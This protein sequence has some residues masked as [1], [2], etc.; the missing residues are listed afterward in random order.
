MF[1]YEGLNDAFATKNNLSKYKLSEDSVT[2]LLTFANMNYIINNIEYHKL[3]FGDPF[4]FKITNKDGK[5]ILDETKRIKSFLSPRR[6]TFDTPEY[7]TFLNNNYNVIE[8]GIELQSGDPGYNKFD[9]YVNTV[10]L[11]D[12]VLAGS[13]SNLMKV[14]SDVKETDGFSWLSPEKYREVKLK[15]GQWSPEAE[16][17]H[18][19]QMAN[20]RNKLAAKGA[21]VYKNKD[22]EQSDIKTISKP[23]PKY[24]LEVLKPI[25]SGVKSASSTIDIVLDKFSQ[26]PIYYG[27]IENTNLEKLYLKMVNENIGYYI[28]ES[29]RKAGAGALHNLYN[30]DGS[31]NEEP[32]S[33]GVIIK[34]PWK[35]YGIQ[36][37]NSYQDNKTQTRGSQ[38]TKLSSL[39]LF[40]NGEP[41]GE[42]EERQE[43]VRKEYDRNKDLL[44]RM[45]ENAYKELL[46]RLGI[47]DLGTSF[48]L[49]D[50]KSVSETLM[51]EM[52][53][54]EVSDNTLDTIQLDDNN[55]FRI[56]LEAS[57]SYIQIRSILYSLI[58][59]A[60]VRPKMS[61]GAHVQ[62]PVTMFEQA[63]KGRSLIRKVEV[64]GVP[65]WTKI[66]K[67]E[68]AK[69]SEEEKKGVVLTDDTL[70][71]Y[72]EKDPYCEIL[73]PAWFK[74]KLS[75]G[76]YK[77]DEDILNYLNTTKEGKAILR[78]IGFRI[79]TQSPSS[80]EVFRVKGFLPDFMGST[81]VV[82]SEIVVKAGSDFDIDKLNMYLKSIYIDA[83]ED[84]R[85]ITLKGTEQET[86]DFY[87][88]V[89]EKTIQKKIDR[90]ER[91]DEFRD[92]LL[93]VITKIESSED[94][95]VD[96]ESLLTEEEYDF[97]DYHI[98]IFSQI[99]EYS[100]E[101]N[102]NGSDYILSQIKDLSTAKEKL[103]SKMLS[104]QLKSDFV[105]DMYKR[106]L[107]NEYYDSLEKLITLPENFK[108]L[109]TP[110]DDAGLKNISDKLD[111]L[112][113]YNESNIK[114]RLLDRNYMTSLRNAFVTAK[115]WVGIAAVNITGHSLAQKIVMYVDPEKLAKF[116][117]KEAALFGDAKIL[118]PHNKVTIDGK[119]YITVSGRL[120]TDGKFISDGLSGYATSFV[121]VAKDPYILKIIGSDLAVGTFMFL[122]RAGVPIETSAIFMNQPIIK[123]YLNL[124][125]ST[126][127]RG[128]F[129][130]KN[131]NT[132]KM[133]FGAPESL[134]SSV[135]ISLGTLDKNIE[136]YYKK[137][138][139][140]E[141]KNAEQQNILNEFLKYAKMAEQLFQFNQATNYD[142]TKFSSGDTLFK[143]QTRT[144]QALDTNIFS[145]VSEVLK[146]SSIGKQADLIDFSMEAVGTILRLEEDQFRVIIDSVLK[147]Y[148]ENYFLNN[149]DYERI[150]N[151]IRASFFDFI[152]Q[153]TTRLN[154]DIV[155]LF[156]DPETSVANRIEK[157]K[158]AFPEAKILQHL[159][160][161]SSG[162]MNGAQSIKLDVNVKEAY[163][164]NMYTG[165]MREL[166][167][168]PKTEDLFQDIVLLSL[169][170]GT[171]QSSIS[172]KN[173]I[174]IE[175]YASFVTPVIKNIMASPEIALFSKGAFQ[176]NNFRDDAV[177]PRVL[178][179]F[180][181]TTESP[182][183][184]DIYGEDVFEYYSPTYGNY[185]V[186]SV[187]ET[188]GLQ[189]T[190][191]KLLF[192]SEKY[193]QQDIK[194]DFVK[195]PRMVEEKGTN[196]RIDVLTGKAI[197]S[198]DFKAMK[199]RGDLA[200][201][202]VLG[203]QKVRNIDG[204]PLVAYYDKEGNAT[205]VY[206]AINLYGD[207][208]YV[209]EY[210]INNTPSKIK[211]G[212]FKLNEEL[213]DETIIEAVYG[214]FKK[215]E[216]VLAVADPVQPTSTSV[217][218]VSRYTDSDVKANPNKIYVFGD[219]TQRTGTG[220]QAQIRNNSNAMGIATK[221]APSN[222]ESAFMIDFDLDKNKVVI[223]G[224]IAKIKA[225]G[226]TLVFP[227]DGL[228]TG[229]AKLKEKAP[230]TYAY[231]KQRL[232][233]E[234]G[235]DNDKGT[236][237]QSTQ[238]VS[239]K[240]LFTVEKGIAQKS[241]RGKPIEF[242]DGITTAKDAI[243]AMSNRD[244]K[245]LVNQKGMEQKF[246]DKAWTTPAKQLDGSFAT[247]L[248]E[249]EFGTFNEWLTFALIHEVKHDTIFKQEGETTGQYED[250]INKAALIDLRENY[251]IPVQETAPGV[252]Y[253]DKEKRI[254]IDYPKTIQAVNS[255]LDSSKLIE[256]SKL[257]QTNVFDADIK[258]YTN[259]VEKVYGPQAKRYAE[260][261]SSEL[262]K[263]EGMFFKNNP[264]FANELLEAYE[265]DELAEDKTIAE[266]AQILLDQNEK[267]V[268]TA[269]IS[270]FD[271]NNE[272][273]EDA[274]EPNPCG[275]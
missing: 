223:D 189:A 224:D 270:L 119:E 74:E 51:R 202:D 37:E 193:N 68:Y 26:M 75:K 203:Y 190:D 58:D 239:K 98:D 140:S 259:E 134:I 100:A 271:P 162:R 90:I 86:K 36:V 66:S 175:D 101:R 174:P 55:Q 133:K 118:L 79:P 209:S 150:A 149:D 251:S 129:N 78:G 248:A 213:A 93:N 220:G 107:E 110:V 33:E 274:D 15:N 31:F 237:S 188:L 73:L 35:A 208:M 145:S 154:T 71:F 131:I 53:K 187:L 11:N 87:A 122:Q 152:V 48:I 177:M 229:L 207:G 14:Y 242:V 49:P 168:N 261:T 180:L 60:I 112:R 125:D 92:N 41:V 25:V 12:V 214:K 231:L 204:S 157:L 232:L 147:P 170:Q 230:Q 191:R 135:G 120:S 153:T 144:R 96:V 195:V 81:V 106:S 234:F 227:K 69:L 57:P 121:D 2:D 163:D 3:L 80:I 64:D 16:A 97:Y 179:K 260:I 273:L 8:E 228:G 241:F 136:E 114:N 89:Y 6:T 21:Y 13:L 105:K 138:S 215:E 84:I 247:P 40:E 142:T 159:E 252:K 221:L 255:E 43:V 222:D 236:I 262:A 56:P 257:K 124:L 197:T 45:H 194:Y 176:R 59:S 109:I 126:N 199:E 4:Q 161:V 1:R 253:K 160:R 139:L 91:F 151:K 27:M 52:L 34:V 77:T 210:N 240:E 88:D 205:Y 225:T 155:N 181:T 256:V 38:I 246:N 17:F 82:P 116:P 108:R 146:Q 183:A 76:K 264:E 212:T 103:T 46:N 63:T 18:K 23:S 99:E 269:Q 219:N 61:G 196:V 169:L 44:D 47:V 171:Y 185:T 166:R 272:D 254:R 164:E 137:G 94:E 238:P 128:L 32:F 28:V 178:P 132:I 143:K 198:A 22:L 19:W 184:I 211:N 65:I 244:G 206:K 201:K 24:K 29:G 263:E 158:I 235:F 50:G 115:K 245:I 7:N 113:G 85:L 10:T 192:L 226:K 70:K 258:N 268:D 104:E 186:S 127:A 148:S 117:E 20:A 233:E 165:Y 167:D 54:R 67:A 182:I 266:Y 216:I 123:E 218:I 267:L 62:V 250:R 200:L 217:E 172:I 83:N 30:P 5:V 72:T 130:K 42:D 9:S 102:M 39:D 95:D 173:I 243:V 265:V 156:V 111:V 275:Q 249:N 141:A